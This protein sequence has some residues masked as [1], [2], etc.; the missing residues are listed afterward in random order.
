[1]IIPSL[2]A[3]DYKAGPMS[4]DP[5]VFPISIQDVVPN[6]LDNSWCCATGNLQTVA[7]KISLL[8]VDLTQYNHMSEG[9]ENIFL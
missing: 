7:V 1:M 2:P 6:S 5:L 4:H 3:K 8:T 9:K